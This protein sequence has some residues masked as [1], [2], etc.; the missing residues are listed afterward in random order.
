M[1]WMWFFIYNIHP[2]PENR[3]TAYTPAY[4]RH[5]ENVQFLNES[6]EFM[7]N[8]VCEGV[9]VAMWEYQINTVLLA[10]QNIMLNYEL[11]KMVTFA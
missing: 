6:S 10:L 4:S 8:L 9:L 1:L 3:H 2:F 5:T 7:H 11:W